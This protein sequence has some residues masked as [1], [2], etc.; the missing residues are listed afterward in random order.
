[1]SAP[2]RLNPSR[3][4]LREFYVGKN[5]HNVPKPALILDRAIMRRHCRS[6]NKAADTLGVGFRAHVKTHKVRISARP[7]VWLLLTRKLRLWKAPDCK[8]AMQRKSNL[9][10]PLLQKSNTCCL[11]SKSI[12]CKEDKSTFCM[13][14]RFLDPRSSA[15][16][17][18]ASTW[19]MAVSRSW[20]TMLIN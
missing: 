7:I 2:Q 18:L 13:A 16:R 10:P 6:L 17:M 14:Y 20:L 15:W 3:D 8:S 19:A 4:S 12:S 9:L 5:I 11:S 1:M